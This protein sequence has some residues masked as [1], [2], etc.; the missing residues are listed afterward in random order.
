[1][2]IRGFF[3]AALIAAFAGGRSFAAGGD[4]GQSG[5]EAGIG[6]ISIGVP[7]FNARM[8]MGFNYDLLRSMTSVSF[9]YPVGYMGFNLP[10]GFSAGLN[11]FLDDETME[12][13]FS[14]G[15]IFKAGKRFKPTAAAEQNANYTVRVDVPML[16]GAGTFAYTQNFFMNFSTAL[17][18]S[19]IIDSKVSIN[20]AAGLGAG[21]GDGV[22][23][24]LSVR[25]ALRLPIDFSMG[26]ETMTFGYAYRVNNNDDLIFALNLHRH[27]F[28][29][30]IRVKA[31]IDILGHASI[32][33]N[34]I[35][36]GEGRVPMSMSVDDEIINFSSDRCNGFAQGRF[37]A[38][39]WTPS[40]GV[41]WK[42]FSLNSRFGLDTK[43]VGSA[44][45][46]FVIPRVVDFETGELLLKD[47]FE[48]FADKI[49]SDPLNVFNVLEDDGG[50]IP[51]GLDSISYEIKD[52][53]RWKMPQG[54]TLS[55]DIIPQKLSVSYTKLFGAVAVE[56]DNIVRTRSDSVGTE[57]WRDPR[58]DTLSVNV[59]VAVDH[60]VLLGVS[61]P[62]FFANV[63]WGGLDIRS[64]GKNVLS[65]NKSLSALRV[66]DVVMLLPI[67]NG[68]FNLGTKLQLR[69]EADI[70]PLPAVRS[71][72][73]YYF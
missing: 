26:W 11:D 18:G 16:G 63:G 66:G 10:V 13:M 12:D 38:E 59:G 7:S 46:G 40:I 57:K 9:Q 15:K 71:G 67:V 56:M 3:A 2:R 51:K 36:V 28:S 1:M 14:N 45:G 70:L 22:S 31:D 25:G 60:I 8:S 58:N 39:A 65:D 44:R 47:K 68:G 62:W 52:S 42:R 6:D 49:E 61:Y 72:V 37:S 20:N 50:I 53:F 23:G 19:S 21:N 54:H 73:N 64:N 29:A 33:A 41:K 43:A 30:D 34:N 55:F 4:D 32:A 5:G 35:D 24:F 17:G 69:V 48:S 27:L